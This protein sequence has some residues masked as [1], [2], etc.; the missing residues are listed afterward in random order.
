MV[1]RRNAASARRAAA[2]Y[3][4]EIAIGVACTLLMLVAALLLAT[5]S[6]PPGWLRA[7]PGNWEAPTLG[8]AAALWGYFVLYL[9][10]ARQTLAQAGEAFEADLPGEVRRA[11]ARLDFQI[12]HA[13]GI[14]LRGFVPV[15]I[16]AGLWVAVLFRLVDSPPAGYLLL[17]TLWAAAF[18]WQTR[19][20]LRAITDRHAPERHELQ[21]LQRQLDE[22]R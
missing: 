8:V 13:R 3:R 6:V 14:V 4:R 22:A 18:V 10:Q 21:T 9:R 11:L 15:W 17:A 20:Q 1:Q 5:H 19:A 2:H 16:A 12:A 7:E